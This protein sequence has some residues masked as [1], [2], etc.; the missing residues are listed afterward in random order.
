MPS[1]GTAEENFS[2]RWTRSNWALDDLLKYPFLEEAREYI[3]IKGPSL[4]EI[5]G[6]SGW[7]MVRNRGKNRVLET[8]VEGRVLDPRVSD[9]VEKEVELF[10]YPIAR[11][12]VSCV[13]DN[14]LVR[15]YSLG[16][17]ERMTKNM[18]DEPGEKVI[19]L[20][21][22]LGTTV[23]R[24]SD[25]FLMSFIDYLEYTKNL[26]ASEWKLVNQ[27]LREGYVVLPKKRLVRVFKEK[28]MEDMIEELPRPVTDALINEFKPQVEEI[29]KVL[30]EKRADFESVDLGRVET[31]LFPPCIKKML[32]LQKEG[33]NL[34][35]EARFA[36]TAFLHKVGLSE[37]QIIA[38]FSE[39]P[40][41]DVD[42]AQYQIEHIIGDI[43]G[44][45]YTPPG[46]GLMKTNGICYDPDRLCEQ[47][48]M[49]H[50][51]TYYSVKKKDKRKNPEKY[52]EDEEKQDDEE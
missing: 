39:S 33:V 15:R 29:K 43:S 31:D 20:G 45:E 49:T 26:K 3:K 12:L 36:L 6:D 50:P 46:C 42:L 44:T 10:S 41:F 21:K 34:S 52:E 32:A 48:W 19:A 38:V 14:Y 28:I 1:S 37:K 4:E 47:D 7:G 13:A 18:L 23:I 8:I 16:E 5:I 30:E 2:E 22:E 17:S 40:D 25:E 11:I 24:D 51:L 35:H 9:E 27:D